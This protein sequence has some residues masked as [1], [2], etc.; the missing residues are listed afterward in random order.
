MFFLNIKLPSHYFL[1]H[2]NY[3][4]AKHSLNIILG[5]INQSLPK[6]DGEQ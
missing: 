3:E 5:N 4:V 1:S 6:K 2:M